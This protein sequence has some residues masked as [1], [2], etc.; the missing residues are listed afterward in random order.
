MK[1]IAM[2]DMKNVLGKLGEGEIIL[3][4]RGADEFKEG[5]LPGAR[6]IPHDQVAQ[7]ASELKKFK[8]I[9]I[10]CQAGRRA[11]MAADAL[12]KLGL[13]NIVCISG[14]GMGDWLAAGLPVER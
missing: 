12:S 14:G 11:G 4:V 3:D 5:H 2:L 9:Y 1:T 6:N 13:T 10:H 8:S 7:H